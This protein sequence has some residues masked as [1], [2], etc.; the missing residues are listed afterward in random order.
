MNR[1]SFLLGQLDPKELGSYWQ[2]TNVAKAGLGTVISAI[3]FVIVVV[4]IWAIFIRKPGRDRPRRYDYP[5]LSTAESSPKADLNGSSGR[6][7]RR[8][9]RRR[10][11][12]RPRKPTLSQTGG[13]PPV[14]EDVPSDDPP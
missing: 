3:S 6:H 9:K 12:H 11:E 5:S 13:L 14:R 10:R 7:S 1:V 8:K 4:L 2:R